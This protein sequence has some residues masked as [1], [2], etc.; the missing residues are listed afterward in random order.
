MKLNRRTQLYLKNKTKGYLSK[1][2]SIHK[3]KHYLRLDLGENLLGHA[4]ISTAQDY[5]GNSILQYYSDP[6]NYRIKKTISSLYKLSPKNII[7]ANN[8][9]EIID[10]LPKMIN[11]ENS[12]NI[13]VLPT[14]FRI[15]D[16]LNQVNSKN[17]YLSLNENI[18]F[19]PDHNLINK[20]IT[21]SNKNHA[22]TIWICNPNNPTGEVYEIRDIEKI[23]RLT[24][25]T[26]IVDE[27]FFEFYDCNNENSAIRLINKYKNLIVLRT[28]SKAYGLAGVRFGYAL[29]NPENIKK[30]EDCRDTLLMTSS[31]VVKLA[32]VALKDKSFIRKTATET[33]KLRNS[34]FNEI[35]KLKNL[36]L[37]SISKSNV[38]ILKHLK[39]DIYKELLNK[40][41]LTADFRNAMGIEGLGY[42]RIT[43]GDKNKNKALIETLKDIN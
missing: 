26:L 39:K 34:L 4:K 25:A 6:S 9:N 42:T 19:I 13:V 33:K 40:N 43:V 36:K 31:L 38:F 5:I 15:I 21:T 28:L 41:I 30:I 35:H 29:S 12:K 27:A 23:L 10:F 14:F 8:S 20:I 16:S 17:L 7:I 2:Q 32:E 22:D 1:D 24:K 37:G 11:E 3:F 18:G